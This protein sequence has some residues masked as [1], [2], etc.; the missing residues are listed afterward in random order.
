MSSETIGASPSNLLHARLKVD[1]MTCGHCAM[2]LN[3]SLSRLDGVAKADVNHATGRADVSYEGAISRDAFREAVREAGFTL[4]EAEDKRS[5][6]DRAKQHARDEL[7]LL[8]WS[9]VI[10][11]PVLVIHFGG[12]MPADHSATNWATW[13][14]FA[15]ATI[16]QPTS[17][18]TYYRGAIKSLRNKRADMD[19]LV[20]LGVLSGYTYACLATFLPAHFPG[21]AMEFF[22]A[23][24]LLIVFIRLGKWVE[25]R[26]R[27]SAAGAMESLLHLA[28][29]TAR[30]RLADGSSEEVGV[31]ALR[32]GDELIVLPGE[33][34]PADGEVLEGSSSANEALLTGESMPVAKSVGDG[35]IAGA[36]NQEAK[37]V[38]KATRVGEDT[39]VNEIVRLV[40]EAQSQRAPI[41]RIA[42]QVSNIFVPA[43]VAIAAASGLYWGFL[44]DVPSSRVLTHVI[45]VMVIACP[46]ALG[47][48]VPAAIMIGSAAG[49]KRGVLVKN[50]A[51]LEKLGK[52]DLI[53][54]DKTG[55]LT[56]G[57]PALVGTLVADPHELEE[58]DALRVAVALAENSTH[59]L[60][61]A[62]VESAKERELES[63]ELAGE[64]SEIAGRGALLEASDGRRFRLGSAKMMEEA[65]VSLDALAKRVADQTDQGAS[66]S[67][68]AK[69]DKLLAAFAFKDPLREEARD[70]IAD[71]N[72]RGVRTVLL[73]GD[74]QASAQAVADE[75]GIQDVRAQLAPSEKL[76][77]IKAWQREG[78]SVGMVGDGINDA[79]ALAAADVGIAVGGG[80]DVAQETGDIVLMQSGIAGLS[81][82][83]ELA[84]RTWRGI[85]QNLFVSLIYNAIGIPLAAGLATIFWPGAVIPASFAALAMVLSDFSVAGN[86][87]R[88]AWELKRV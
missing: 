62:L 13:L 40:E 14:V 9:F 85:K 46:C 83:M 69:D 27:A 39:A 56:I 44:S 10:T 41:Q 47:L 30:R 43:V 77:A 48:A 36:T 26:A 15:C 5:A 71:L 22:E 28:P 67:Y 73:S 81:K 38:V 80:T 78:L 11:L 66:I 20:S 72:Q 50:G 4:I 1:G 75:L 45:G 21:H 16:L 70:V 55:T 17:A 25:S 18:I 68:L 52:L 23:A 60:S 64:Q 63:V 51:A 35:V 42:D 7:R 58:S 74:L 59:P 53:A 79:P 49:M 33:R 37:L 86:S 76:D 84:R 82:A 31:D 2:T 19:V 61:R 12:F 88:L 3:K 29:H 32:E 65:G 6:A 87:A 57:E 8:I 24:T 54:F 34:F